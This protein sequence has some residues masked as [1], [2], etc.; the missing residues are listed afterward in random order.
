MPLAEEQ[1]ALLPEDIRDNPTVQKYDDVG[2]MAKGLIEAQSFVG[3]SI[4]LPAKDSKPEDIEK[5]SGETSAKLKDY[6]YTIA[7]PTEPPPKGPEAYEF[8]VEGVTPQQL[9]EDVGVKAFRGFAHKNGLSNA[10]AQEFIDFYAKEVVPALYNEMHKEDPQW[11]E[12]PKEV[13][14]ILSQEFKNEATTR[15]EEFNQAVETLARNR[16][17]IKDALLNGISQYGTPPKWV[18]NKDNPEF[19]WAFSEFARTSL[20]QDFGG[21]MAGLTASDS[22]ESVNDEI[23][24]LRKEAD[25]SNDQFDREKIGNKMTALYRK[26]QVL[27]M[28]NGRR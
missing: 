8:K 9:A 5:W 14:T 7:K 4:Q 1:A 15:R 16:Q 12:D 28:R 23:D 27:E 13:E 11:I 22:I 19:I 26:R 25:A 17:S 21:H 3:R 24:K 2:G 18:E 10:K 6:G 20:K